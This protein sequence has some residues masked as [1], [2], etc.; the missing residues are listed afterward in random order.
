VRKRVREKEGGE[1]GGIEREKEGGRNRGKY[2]ETRERK[3]GG[4]E[5]KRDKRQTKPSLVTDIPLTRKVIK[6]QSVY[7]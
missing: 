4:G 1:R 2:G 3:R 7:I 5:G 6:W